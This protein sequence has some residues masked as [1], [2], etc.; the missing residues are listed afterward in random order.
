MRCRVCDAEDFSPA[1][2]L[3]MQP[4]GHHFLK[5]EELGQEPTYPLRV[6]YCNRCQTA[7]LDHTVKKEVMYTDHTY[8]SGMTKSL[9]AH[10]EEIAREVD[11]TFF[12][13]RSSKRVLDIGSNDG[14]QLQYFKALGYEVLGV[15]AA[16][17]IAQ[18]ANER[19][20]PTLHRFFNLETAREI[21]KPFDVINAAGVFFHLEELHSVTQGIQHLL[22]E[23]GV[24]CVQFLYMKCIMENGAFDQIYHEHLLYYTLT[25]LQR[26]LQRHGLQLLMRI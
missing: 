18:I 22:K 19:G 9:L 7:Q 12:A 25:T 5:E 2:D 20:I 26:L 17:R 8:L 13:D 21:A 11:T 1:I 15:E 14:S 6:I 23:D 4:L 16:G 3:G 10:F 24:F